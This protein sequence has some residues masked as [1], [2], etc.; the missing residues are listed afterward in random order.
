MAQARPISQPRHSALKDWSQGGHLTPA[1]PL[2]T[3][4]GCHSGAGREGMSVFPFPVKTG[5]PGLAGT[6]F[7][8]PESK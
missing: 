2:G 8:C 3:F 6:A 1:G 7:L 4:V 5:N